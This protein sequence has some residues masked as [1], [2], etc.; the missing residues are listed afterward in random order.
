MVVIPPK[1]IPLCTGLPTEKLNHCWV[2]QNYLPP[3]HKKQQRTQ[4][5]FNAPKPF[6]QK[7]FKIKIMKTTILVALLAQLLRCVLTVIL[8]LKQSKRHRK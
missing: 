5:P 3:V 7:Q 1:E 2:I 4:S 8:I 6:E